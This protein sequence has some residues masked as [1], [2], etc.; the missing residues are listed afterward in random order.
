MNNELLISSLPPL[1]QGPTSYFTENTINRGFTRPQQ[2]LATETSHPILHW[3]N[4]HLYTVLTMMFPP[5]NKGE[6]LL[7]PSNKLFHT[8][9]TVHT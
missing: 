5:D 2:A 9:R 6:R 4:E 7:A 1:F 3:R 8:T